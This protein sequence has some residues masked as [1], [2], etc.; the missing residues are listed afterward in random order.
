LYEKENDLTDK[1]KNLC[2]T[3]FK[4]VDAIAN[5]KGMLKKPLS[6]G[7]LH[8]LFDMV[9][10]CDDRGF[11]IKDHSKFFDFFLN[12]DAE[13]T[14]ISSNVIEDELEEKSYTYWTKFFGSAS[15]YKN[16][17]YLLEESLS[18]NYQ[19]LLEKEIISYKRTSKDSYSFE[20]QKI[21][22]TL[23]NA[24][25][26]KGA[27]IK[28]IDLYLGKYEVDHMKSVHDGGKTDLANSE[29]MTE[30]DNRSKGSNSNKPC[31]E[32]QKIEKVILA[33]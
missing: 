3:I 17:R 9:Q 10:L 32:H 7:L 12:Q 31:F 14:C 20:D 27:K 6:K 24:R 15:N 4:E 16:I 23:Q 19:Q 22:Y 18:L 11:K 5:K 25:D 26:R 2:K 29:L 8:N 30:F 28:I 13:W 33:E 1:V 21:L